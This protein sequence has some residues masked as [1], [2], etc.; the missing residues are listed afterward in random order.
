MG[1]SRFGLVHLGDDPD[2]PGEPGLSWLEGPDFGPRWPFGD[3]VCVCLLGGDLEGHTQGESSLAS[4]ILDTEP[5]I[6]NHPFIYKTSCLCQLWLGASHLA[7]LSFFL[8]WRQCSRQK[9]QAPA[10]LE[11]G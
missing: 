4:K 9:G 7:H 2:N 1:A 6:L 11:R 8:L 5:F 3:G 10:A